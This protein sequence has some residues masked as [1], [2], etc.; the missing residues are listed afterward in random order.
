MEYILWARKQGE[1]DW[2][3]EVITET[4]DK[5]QLEK[6]KAWAK[7]NGYED[8]RVM[9]YNGEAPDFNT[10]LKVKKEVKGE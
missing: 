7:A 9:E 6:S 3:E 5:K 1:P 2:M 10:P 8:L 4:K